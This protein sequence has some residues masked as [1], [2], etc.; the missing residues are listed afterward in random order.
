MNHPAQPTLYRAVY[1]SPART[2]RMT[3]SATN[4]QR[5]ARIAADWIIAED[6]ELLAVRAIR[7]LAVQFRLTGV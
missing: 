7:R 6:E 1:R 2:R 5:A 3:F 4:D